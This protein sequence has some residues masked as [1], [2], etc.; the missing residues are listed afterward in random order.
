[1]ATECG[2]VTYDTHIRSLED[3]VKVDIRFVHMYSV[4][5]YIYTLIH[6]SIFHI[7]LYKRIHLAFIIGVV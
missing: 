7:N 3:V 6:E 1:M 2:E 4:Y 5:I